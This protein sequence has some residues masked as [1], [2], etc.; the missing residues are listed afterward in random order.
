[1]GI[2]LLGQVGFDHNGRFLPAGP[3]KQSG[4]LTALAM[5]PGQPVAVALLVDRIWDDDPPS[6]ARG[7]LYA[8]VARLRKLLKSRSDMALR[9]SNAGYVLAA[10]RSL[11]DVYRMRGL[12]ADG[13]R[14]AGAGD[15]EDA[16]RLWQ[17]SAALWHGN[18]PL[19][20]VP[21]AWAQ[22]MRETLERERLDTLVEL[23]GAKLRT[24][25]HTD[26]VAEL[27]A[28][29]ADHPLSEA[30]TAH[31]MLALHR[32]GRT[33]EALSCFAMTRRRLRDALGC[34]PSRPLA[35]LH[36]RMLCGDPQ[37]LTSSS[38]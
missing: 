38:R 17:A 11:V 32:C 8:Y 2:R 35:S 33:G 30:L 24:G 34:E 31:L 26:V 1:M 21:G 12:A 19:A 15:D 20:G 18:V 7:S 25:R 27:S 29:V 23:Y 37:L 5:S 10:D 36:Q 4:V 6:A 13:Q 9:H 16:I 28:L 14:A 3:A 22:R